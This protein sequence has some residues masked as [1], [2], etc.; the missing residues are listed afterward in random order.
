MIDGIDTGVSNTP[1]SVPVIPGIHYIQ[2]APTDIFAGDIKQLDASG[3][4]SVAFDTQLSVRASAALTKAIDAFFNQCAQAQQ[5]GPAGCPNST[6]PTGDHQ[7]QIHWT[8]LGDP[9]TNVKLSSGD[10]VETVIAAGT[11]QMHV[12]YDYWAS[13]GH[14]RVQH[15]DEDI[16]GVFADTLLWNG[17]AFEVTS[18]SGSASAETNGTSS[19]PTP[20]ITATA[21]AGGGYTWQVVGQYFT[22]GEGIILYLYDPYNPPTWAGTYA[23]GVSVRSDGSFTVSTFEMTGVYRPRPGT[24]MIKVCDDANLCAT[25]LITVS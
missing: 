16:S 7:S 5:L 2:L 18:H 12:A 20:S 14:A 24:A 3:D 13:S 11:W 21:M 23:P 1:S 6:S 22:P 15:W 9:S 17:S 8:L 25:V 10:A 19:V 4:T